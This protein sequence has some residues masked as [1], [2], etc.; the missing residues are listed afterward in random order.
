MSGPLQLI[1]ARLAAAQP[2]LWQMAER[3]AVQKLKLELLP[4]SGWLPARL[5]CLSR[6]STAT[7]AMSKLS[8]IAQRSCGAE[9][10]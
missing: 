8:M 5:H 10:L 2:P 1:L 6:G 3:R 4:R 7:M 9:Y